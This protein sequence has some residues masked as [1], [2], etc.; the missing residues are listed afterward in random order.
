MALLSG[1]ILKEELNKHTENVMQR[2]AEHGMRLD[3]NN[4]IKKN[5]NKFFVYIFSA[6]V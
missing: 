2:L 6:G 3:K 5:K 4:C 1:H